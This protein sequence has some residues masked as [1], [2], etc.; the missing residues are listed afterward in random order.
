M[1]IIRWLK[2]GAL[3]LSL[4]LLAACGGGGEAPFAVGGSGAGGS[5]TKGTPT[6]SIPPIPA[7][8][9]LSTPATVT[10]TLRD[11][12]G[13]PVAGQVIALTI[14]R[15]ALATLSAASVLTDSVGRA[16]VTITAANAGVAG[17]DELVAET[18]IGTTAVKGRVGFEVN[19]A[20]P[21]LDAPISPTT[22]RASTGEVTWTATL[23][24]AV[25]TLVSG[26]IVRF[27]STSG[28]VSLSAPSAVTN[29]AGQA[30]VKVTVSNPAINDTDELIASA[31]VQG[32][33]LQY[34]AVVQ[35]VGEQP[36]ISPTLV[37]TSVSTSAPGTVR[38]QVLNATGG[39][40]SAVIVSFAT[41]FGLGRFTPITATSDFNGMVTV[42]LSPL[43]S[44]TTG[45]DEIVASATVAG[46]AT[47][48]RRVVQF[49]PVTTSG[50]AKLEMTPFSNPSVSSAAPLT[51]T[52]TLTN[53]SG[54]RV[55]GQVV[56]F[57]TVRSLGVLSATTALTD[58]NG[59][60]VVVLR[61]INSSISGADEVTATT[62]FGGQTLQDLKGF[63][64]Q[65]TGVTITGFTHPLPPL[66]SLGAYGQT[67]L[68]VNTSGASVGSPVGFT[69]TS[70]CAA[71]AKATVS[72]A[73]FTA[74][75]ASTTLQ[76]KDNGCGALQ[77]S[78]Q[79]QVTIVGTA[80]SSVLSLP[81]A[82]PA[83]AS[84]AF[85]DALPN[86]IYLKGSG[87]GESS[88]VTFEVRDSA[89]NPLPNRVVTMNL[90]TLAG[91]ALIEGAQT[92]VTRTSDASGRVSVRLNSGTVPTPLRVAASLVEG[93]V[94]ISTV[95]SNLSVA[96]G[97]PSQLNFSLSQRTKNIEGY[98][99]D[100]T[101]NTYTVTAADRN[102]N[103]VP[104]GT[105]INFVTEGGQIEAIRQTTLV[106]GLATTS[107]NFV[108]ASPRPIDG[109]VTITTYALGEE[110]FIDAGATDPT[111][112][113]NNTWAPG[114]PFQALGHVFKDRDFNGYNAAEDELIP[115]GTGGVF[116]CPAPGS[117]L[118]ALDVSIPSAGGSTC[119]SALVPPGWTGAGKVYVRRAA[120]TVLST[121]GAR[122]TW[123][124]RAGLAAG[125]TKL[126]LK[127]SPTTT[128]EF[129][130]VDG[131]S[132]WY[133]NGNRLG[134]L[135]ISAADAN[136]V[137]F[138]PMAQGTTITAVSTEGMAVEVL[139]GTVPSSS[140]PSVAAI[141]FSFSDAPITTAGTITLT[142]TSPSGVPTLRSINM[143][144]GVNPGA[145]CL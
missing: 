58:S 33:D 95:S 49:V 59:Q 124:N 24:N 50:V 89:G 69:V 86:Q 135:L 1:K 42:T 113:G 57:A 128:Q 138:N 98:N 40:V 22:L 109:R 87:L 88:Q 68:T 76:F 65:A 31:R 142:F 131:A 130:V 4:A 139:G 125:C 46:V 32:V 62:S 66:T 53:A 11:G 26:E 115:L 145:S 132:V 29:G 118:L 43:L 102:G 136:P 14:T 63:Q 84:L 30:S 74:T 52:V 51:V 79:L 116:A 48:L 20:T 143:Q 137:R 27:G 7:Q 104:A 111:L 123:A 140:D 34:R 100:G 112:N 9:T 107:A 71:L 141:N 25:G 101:T 12:A 70:A 78:D 122:P 38:V 96:V 110:S 41:T 28:R 73:T 15:T 5:T 37:P 60:A 72:P 2:S 133:N 114:K 120:E 54:V 91:G 82:S 18:T 19:V 35:V 61:P 103:P 10:M 8:I 94:T 127:I 6:L 17:A 99:I 36:S 56:S 16:R 134:Q 90:L 44:S 21:S 64:V 129:T 67:T 75:T 117:P 144:R 45:A 92:T 119:N 13:A 47:Q 93:A 108:S 3:A 85:I 55:P 23:K 121:S 81:I 80:I 106:N 83:V 126:D 97:L 77:A 39:P 105:S